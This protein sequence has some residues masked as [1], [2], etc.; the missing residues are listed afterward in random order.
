MEK[1]YIVDDDKFFASALRRVFHSAG[2]EVETFHSARDFLEQFSDC[3][4]ACLILDLRMPEIG[5]LELLQQ[6]RAAQADI[7]VIIYTGNADVAVAVK[8]MQAG[9]FSVTEK[10]FSNELMIAEV[11]AAIAAAAKARA[12]NSLL[13]DAKAKIASLSDRERTLLPLLGEGHS[14]REAADSLGLSARTVEAHRANIFRK[15][16][17]N[18]TAAL[19]RIVTLAELAES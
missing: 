2:F 8:A 9:A 16:H 12:R 14:A 11:R 17:I 10:P 5:G 7:P 6:L 19:V 1:I 4:S 18:S 15:L 13:R 3:G